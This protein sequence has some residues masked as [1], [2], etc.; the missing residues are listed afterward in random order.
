MKHRIV[1]SGPQMEPTNPGSLTKS[2]KTVESDSFVI[3]DGFFWFN[4][5]NDLVYLVDQR[6]VHS[7]TVV[8]ED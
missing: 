2:T 7:V 3:T 4:Q 6:C 5:G 8:R 1:I